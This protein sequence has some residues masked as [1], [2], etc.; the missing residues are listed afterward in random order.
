MIRPFNSVP[1][2]LSLRFMIMLTAAVLILSVLFSFVL[3]HSV[4]LQQNNDLEQA[5][6]EIIKEME[7]LAA[8]HCFQ[9]PPFCS[10]LHKLCCIR[11]YHK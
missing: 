2:K 10:L 11:L 1:V 9:L 7:K 5:A 3:G 4:R 6:Q 8:D